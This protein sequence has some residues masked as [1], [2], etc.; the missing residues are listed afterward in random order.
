MTRSS[1]LDAVTFEVGGIACRIEC[2]YAKPIL[3]VTELHPGFRSERA[4]DVVVRFDYDDSYWADGLPWIAPDQ[5]VDAPVYEAHAHGASLRSAY[6]HA[7]IDGG[8]AHVVTRIAGGFGVG[9]MLRALYATLLPHRGACLVRAS[10]HVTP[11]GVVLELGSPDHGV[12][13][14]VPDQTFVAVEP[15]PFHHGTSPSRPPGRRVTVIDVGRPG[16][17]R[18]ETAAR[19]LE[20]AVVVDHSPVVLERALDVVARLVTSTTVVA[21]IASERMTGVGR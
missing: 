3:W 18:L 21:G 4:P 1:P 20:H 10:A 7:E 12:V 16:A 8:G 13:A 19:T 15:T 11:D 14:V 6:Y 9:G 17:T 2:A 5:L